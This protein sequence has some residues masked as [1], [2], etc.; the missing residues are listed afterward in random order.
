[1]SELLCHVNFPLC[2]LSNERPRPRKVSNILISIIIYKYLLLLLLL[3]LL[4]VCNSY[5][6]SVMENCGE[7]YTAINNFFVDYNP[8]VIPECNNYD[9]S[10]TVAGD[11]PECYMPIS[12]DNIITN[13]SKLTNNT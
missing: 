11:N 2:D 5:C 6:K 12:I 3:L 1:M 10:E 4:K 9:S 13:G 8:L 7:F